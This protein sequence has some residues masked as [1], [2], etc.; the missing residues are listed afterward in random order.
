MSWLNK[1][2]GYKVLIEEKKEQEKE[3]EQET[4][5]SSE[6]PLYAAA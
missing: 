1:K 5:K 6:D 2:K 4:Y 3:Q